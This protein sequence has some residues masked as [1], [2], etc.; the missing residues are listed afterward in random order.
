MIAIC[1]IIIRKLFISILA[2]P[3]VTSLERDATT[4]TCNTTGSPP[5]VI[6]W[7]KNGEP[8]PRN[9]NGY[10][11]NEILIDGRMATFANILTID[12]PPA[13]LVGTYSCSV[14]NAIGSSNSEQLE[15]QGLWFCIVVTLHIFTTY[16]TQ[17]IMQIQQFYNILQI[18][19]QI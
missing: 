12:L 14:L 2:P 19:N 17:Y 8:L 16:F 11:M 5:T 9:K 7:T 4:L 6:T 13:D 15:V 3:V 18:G 10:K 1:T